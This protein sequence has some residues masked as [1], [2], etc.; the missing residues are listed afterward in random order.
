[1]TFADS[2]RTCLFE[3]YATFSGRASRSEYWWFFLAAMIVGFA[4][5]GIGYL[6]VGM[7]A[8]DPN[9]G[10]GTFLIFPISGNT[11]WD[12]VN[13]AVTLAILIPSIAVGYRRMQDRNVHGMWYVLL[14]IPVYLGSMFPLSAQIALGVVTII[15]SLFVLVMFVMRGTV[16]PNKYGPDPL[17]AGDEEIFT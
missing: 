7:A 12:V 9:V 10:E 6:L 4:M 14:M 5:M 16:G 2:V 1:M 11:A 3:K 8:I 17:G 13:G 15:A